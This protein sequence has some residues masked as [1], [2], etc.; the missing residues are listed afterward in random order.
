MFVYLDLMSAVIVT[1]I[2]LWLNSFI[3]SSI[4]QLTEFKVNQKLR[5]RLH[6]CYRLEATE[7]NITKE[8]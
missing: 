4:L 7:K 6:W 2:F 8:V 1:I 3:F 5:N